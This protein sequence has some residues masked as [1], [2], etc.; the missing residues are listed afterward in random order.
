MIP[1]IGCD[2]PAHDRA[3]VVR[4][5]FTSSGRQRYR[6][7]PVSGKPHTFSRDSSADESELDVMAQ[8]R[9]LRYRHTVE[10]I[11]TALILVGKGATYRQAAINSSGGVSDNAQRVVNWI[12]RFGPVV[13][14][15]DSWR[16][17]PA[18]MAVDSLALRGSSNCDV[19]VQLAVSIAADPAPPRLWKCRIDTD[20]GDGGPWRNLFNSHGG[21]PEVLIVR[22]G[23]RAA[24]AALRI[25]SDR[26]PLLI[27]S[28]RWHRES[29]AGQAQAHPLSDASRRLIENDRVPSVVRHL[30]A[31][32]RKLL[33]EISHRHAHFKDLARLNLVLALMRAEINGDADLAEYTGRI[34]EFCARN[35][36]GS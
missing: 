22:R 1:F 7:V 11:A 6:C 8:S 29:V 28:R 21:R 32:R 27:D 17:W 19:V 24:V 33:Q 35:D 25:W 10:E 23:S 12:Q 31:A 5:G 36:Y 30:A 4:N 20:T 2:D 13:S 3:L 18:V 26:P 34:A 14:P 9:S 15:A 16:P